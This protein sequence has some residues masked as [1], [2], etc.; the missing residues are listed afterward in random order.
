MP[1]SHTRGSVNVTLFLC[2]ID[3]LKD[4][5][6][7]NLYN[8]EKGGTQAFFRHVRSSNHSSARKICSMMAD[9]AAK[10]KTPLSRGVFQTSVEDDPVVLEL[11]S[12]QVRQIFRLSLS[13][14]VYIKCDARIG[15]LVAHLFHDGPNSVP[16]SFIRGGLFLQH[17][18][19]DDSSVSSTK[20]MKRGGN[21]V[22]QKKRRASDMDTADSEQD[23]FDD[24]SS[25]HGTRRGVAKRKKKTKPDSIRPPSIPS[26]YTVIMFLHSLSMAKDKKG[27]PAMPSSGNQ[28]GVA[29]FTITECF[30]QF[31][32]QISSTPFFKTILPYLS[33]NRSR[34]MF[35]VISKRT[36][37]Y[38]PLSL[39]NRLPERSEDPVPGPENVSPDA[40]A[41]SNEVDA[42]WRYISYLY[43]DSIQ[44]CVTNHLLYSQGV[45][46]W[47]FM[48]LF[49]WPVGSSSNSRALFAPIFD[50]VPSRYAKALNMPLPAT[51]LTSGPVDPLPL[52]SS[53]SSASS[54]VI[55]LDEFG[56]KIQKKSNAF[57]NRTVLFTKS[58][59]PITY[60]T[61]VFKTADRRVRRRLNNQAVKCESP[62]FA[63][64]TLSHRRKR[65]AENP[66]VKVEDN[67]V[68]PASTVSLD[69]K[70]QTAMDRLLTEMS[71]DFSHYSCDLGELLEQ[72]ELSTGRN[73]KG[74]AD[75]VLCDP[76]YNIRR[77]RNK[78]NAA[79]DIFTSQ[80]CSRMIEEI[81]NVLKLGGHAHIFCST[82]Q[83]S[84]WRNA[85]RRHTTSWDKTSSSCSSSS[86]SSSASSK[87]GRM[88]DDS[89]EESDR[90]S[91]TSSSGS[92]DETAAAGRH[93]Q[94]TKNK[95]KKKNK[96][97]VEEPTF[98]LDP[99][100]IHYVRQKGF[101]NLDP[102]ARNGSFQSMVE[103]AI[104]FWKRGAPKRDMLSNINYA[105][106]ARHVPSTYPGWVNC[107]DNI[108]RPEPD[109]IIYESADSDTRTVVRQEQKSVR[110]MMDIIER[111]TK[112]GALVVD[113]TAGTFPVMKAC[114]SMPMHRKFVGCD[115]DDTCVIAT[116][117]SLVYTFAQ[118]LVNPDSDV[119]PSCTE[120]LNV[121]RS[122]IQSYVSRQARVRLNR[123]K[124][125]EGL[126]P[127]QTV[128][129]HVISYMRSYFAGTAM[130]SGMGNIVPDRWPSK[131]VNHFRSLDMNAVRA[132]E[133]L[134]LGVS[135]K[136]SSIQH[137]SAGLGL[138]AE[139]GFGEKEVIGFYYGS[140]VYKALDGIS[141]NSQKVYGEGPFSV[142]VARFKKYA[143]QIGYKKNDTDDIESEKPVW[144]VPAPCCVVQFVNDARY[145]PG[146]KE[147]GL[148]G[149][150]RRKNNCRI[151]CVG[152]MTLS[153]L[154]RYDYLMCV[155]MRNISAGEEL[156]MSY[157][158]KYD[159]RKSIIL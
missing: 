81:A 146:D 154:E 101:Y 116:E 33:Y 41:L 74:M 19:K 12:E 46:K 36:D 18:L 62:K 58:D 122:F 133:C 9:K 65:E 63:T 143:M 35:S 158:G 112:P 110:W 113:F 148:L 141:D 136:K 47:E 99:N 125:P 106:A 55:M 49:E 115:L 7:Y 123:W 22:W 30:K 111:M 25:G 77:L 27:V 150:N 43:L 2:F 100:I 1:T 67:I 32:K 86:S 53:S 135:I 87:D 72:H 14:L 3:I 56:N 120:I 157:G 23:D 15:Q 152:K 104:H 42:A 6:F 103:V 121:A 90:R 34:C 83:Q 96:V 64:E 31:K 134:A 79:H 26:A 156:Y 50:S 105:S 89:S 37:G 70:A 98:E 130:M 39:A 73:M 132:A 13:V 140:L 129:P 97:I 144:V 40:F 131:W 28:I 149:S 117:E 118:Q 151:V 159:F 95:S 94:S 108:P 59:E 145:L 69:N 38:S 85:I 114:M 91:K 93:T 124:V 5:E 68:L 109:E 29:V 8:Q 21:N 45:Q 76:P 138:Y 71:A 102:R 24:D 88:D 107:V 20:S 155:A 17:A 44:K 52:S 48:K 60:D 54:D 61:E 82:E 57:E 126:P 119:K 4:E 10:R 147:S 66:T 127:M 51:S 84:V 142:S 16:L 92:G 80:D 75:L 11:G 137:P 139:T 78:S 153:G 128:P